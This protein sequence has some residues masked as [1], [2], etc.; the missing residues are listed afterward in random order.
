M[1]GGT[2]AP[3]AADFPAVDAGKVFGVGFNAS[4]QVVMGA[5]QTGIMGVLVLTKKMNAGD[6]VDVMR[7][8]EITEFD[9]APQAIGVAGTAYEAAAATGVVSTLEGAVATDTFIG[10]TVEAGRLVV[11]VIPKVGV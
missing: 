10:H 6:I 2:R 9:L 11:N 4:G 8:G 3:L 1:S 5:G 7:S